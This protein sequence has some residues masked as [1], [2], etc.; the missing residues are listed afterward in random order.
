MKSTEKCLKEWNAIVEALGHGKQTI[1]IRKYKTNLK[2]FL[3]Y[4]TVSYTNENDYLKSFQEKHHSFVEKYSFPHKEGEKTE[5]KYFATVEKIL[6]RPPRIIPSE[7]FYIWRRGHVKSY[8]NGKN[9]YIWVLRVY[10]L[11]KPYMAD[12]AYGPGVYANLKERVSLKG[13]EPVLTDKEFSETLEKLTPE[14]SLQYGYQTLRDELAMELLENIRSC[15]TGFFKK[16]IVD[17]LLKMGYGGSRKDA[18]E[19][20]E[21]GGDGGIEGIIKEDKLGLDTIYIQAKRGSISRP[22]I[23]KFASA[24]E[25]QAKKGVFIT[26][27]S[28]SRAAQE[29][30]SSIDNR[31]VLIDGDE[32]AQLMIDH[33]VGVSK[34]TSYEIK[35]IDTDYFSE[36]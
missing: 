33:H 32:L 21:K 13:A 16:M 6:E 23:Q 29:Y 24:L 12:L 27:S 11:K 8:L 1:L 17:L 5:I 35:K 34:V 15:S 10:R 9:A 28:F 2:E 14:E 36:E 30:A 31:I 25:G 19:A 4:P 20:I 7:N 22:E 3:L 26:T 18:D